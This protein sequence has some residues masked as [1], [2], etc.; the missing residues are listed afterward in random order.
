MLDVVVVGAGPNGLAAAITCAEAGRSVVVVEATDAIGGGTQTRELTLPGFRHD[1]CSAIHPL[2]A[3]SP[4]FAGAG[5]E[6]HGLE[7][8]HPEVAL[9]HP[10]DDGRAGV[11]HRSVEETVAGL[12]ADGRSWERH[13]GWT[14]RRWDRLSEAVLGPLLRVP[15]HPITLGGFGARGALPATTFGRAFHTDEARALL[16]GC[17]AHAFLPLSRPFTA[18]MGIML[19][20]S[21]HVA[22][23]PVAKGGSEAINQAMASRLAELGGT[24]EVGRPVRS[25]ADVPASRAV[26][27]DLTP[28]QLLAVCGDALP[29]A[30]RRRMG[31]YKYGPAAFKVDYA[32]SEPVPWTNPSA[33]R[34]GSLHLGGTL[35]EVAHAEAEVAAGRPPDHPFL[36]VGQQSLIDPTRAPAGRHTLWTYC[37]VPNGSRVDMVDA[38][39]RQIERFA[40]GFRDV[41]LA[42][43]VASPA[44]FEAHNE[45]F[46]GGDIA[47][48]SHGGLQLVLRPRPGVSP[49]RTPDPRLFVCSAATPPGA[50]VH[51]MCGRNAAQAALR[52]T[53]R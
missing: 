23:W 16:A 21:A 3:V 46:I 7:L 5:L 45:S 34:A 31:K 42:R 38:M 17:S 33:R 50:G 9:V 44:W 49:Y 35:E 43:H 40:P 39:E 13:I 4:F 14:A 47:G 28:R 20:A 36:L 32:L 48:G 27:F 2:A 15:Q 53:L 30:Y 8:L 6:R 18:S 26:L 29:A 25:L 1:V 19:L 41:V 37:H 12:G 22:G 24:I 10:L 11:L 51:G 52:T